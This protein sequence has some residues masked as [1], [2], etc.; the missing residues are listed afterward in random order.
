MSGS[1]SVFLL[2]VTSVCPSVCRSHAV[3]II[4]AII[5]MWSL[6]PVCFP[7]Q[8]VSG[9]DFSICSYLIK[10]VC[11]F[12]RKTARVLKDWLWIHGSVLRCG[13]F[14]Y[15]FFCGSLT[16]SFKDVWWEESHGSSKKNADCAWVLHRPCT[17]PWGK[18]GEQFD[19]PLAA[20]GTWTSW[21]REEEDETDG[22][23]LKLG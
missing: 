4:T 17:R 6:L 21:E 19:F 3:L 5:L 9:R 22:Y 10:S 20:K 14:F 1:I 8:R 2:C 23:K 18:D 16:F 12:F 11:H 7:S 13:M 15:P